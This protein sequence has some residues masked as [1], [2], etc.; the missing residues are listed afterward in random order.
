MKRAIGLILIAMAIVIG[1]L[2]VRGTMPFIPIFGSSMK[3]V[4]QPGS[5]L[6]IKPV[7]TKEIKVGDII[8]YNVPSA[9]QEYYNYPPVVAHRVIKIN[10]QIGSFRTKGDNTGEDPFAIMPGDVRGVVGN[11]IEY[12]GFPLLFLQSKQGMIFIIVSLALLVFFLYGPELGQG[13][14]WLQRGAFSPVIQA[15]HRTNRVLAQ[16]IE[17]TEQRMDATQQA[18]E[19][20]SAAIELYAQH[21][22]SHT[23]AIQGLSEASHELKR[24]AAEQNRVLMNLAQNMEFKG[25]GMARKEETNPQIDRLTSAFR[26]APARTEKP[27]EIE[28]KPAELKH[29]PAM[30][31]GEQV[32]PGCAISRKALLKR[33]HEMNDDQS[34]S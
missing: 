17:T 7:D 11:Q 22:A 31:G 14:R 19:K 25:Q 21:L 26:M 6:L 10:E 27:P 8:V 9:I 30:V 13:G 5:L 34:L 16:K 15:S 23:S 18:L 1:F 3:P 28:K 33:I 2:T 24:S 4:L 12:L 20:F 29:K 32:P